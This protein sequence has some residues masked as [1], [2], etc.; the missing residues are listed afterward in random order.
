[1]L[2]SYKKLSA[3]A[4][5]GMFAS[6]CGSGQGTNGNW[7]GL[8]PP[9]YGGCPA[10]TYNYGYGCVSNGANFSDSCYF[11][12]GTLQQIGGKDLCVTQKTFSLQG[13]TVPKL[14]SSQASY[15]AWTLSQDIRVHDVVRVEGSVEYG[16]L[17]WEI[18]SLNCKNGHT[19]PSASVQMMVSVG[20]DYFGLSSGQTHVV[21]SN[22]QLRLGVDDPASYSCFVNNNLRVIV[23]RCQDSTGMNYPC[24]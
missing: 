17:G 16:S 18:F 2:N 6:A 15:G 10:G 9:V 14:S 7:G 4:L 11:N 22:G 12:G 5:L 24:Q 20:S 1:M 8:T 21:T 3:I 19:A 13:S 23:K